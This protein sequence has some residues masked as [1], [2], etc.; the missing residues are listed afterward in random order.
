MHTRSTSLPKTAAML[1]IF[2]GV[3][4]GARGEKLSKGETAASL[5]MQ[6][7][8]LRS[9]Y[10]ATARGI[11][12]AAKAFGKFHPHTFKA[13]LGGLLGNATYT[14]LAATPFISNKVARMVHDKRMNVKSHHITAGLFSDR[15]VHGAAVKNV[16]MS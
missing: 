5:A 1:G 15:D 11:H 10:A 6:A 3:S 16:V 13:A 2:V 7:P 4:R 9:E 14:S 8:M 12:G